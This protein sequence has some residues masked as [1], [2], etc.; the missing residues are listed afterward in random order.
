MVTTPEEEYL[1]AVATF[2]NT[3]L[4]RGVDEN[5]LLNGLAW[6]ASK[7]LAQDMIAAHNLADDIDQ[8]VR[9]YGDLVRELTRERIRAHDEGH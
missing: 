5:L 6:G 3:W 2:V 8:A 9:I 4:G 1:D 7:V